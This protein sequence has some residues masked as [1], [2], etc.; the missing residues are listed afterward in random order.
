MRFVNRDSWA[1]GHL[2]LLCVFAPPE[3]ADLLSI[4]NLDLLQML[5]LRRFLIAGLS[6]RNR[7]PRC[8][9]ETRGRGCACA[10][11]LTAAHFASSRRLGTRLV[12]TAKLCPN[13][14]RQFSIRVLICQHFIRVLEPLFP[15]WDMVWGMR[16]GADSGAAANCALKKGLNVAFCMLNGLIFTFCAGWLRERRGRV[17]GSKVPRGLAGAGDELQIP[18][19]EPSFRAR[20][21]GVPTTLDKAQ[22]F[23]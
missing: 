8:R 18:R 13:L 14:S 21:V 4:R 7:R 12:Y 19:L 22:K 15:I 23:H 9:S 16:A 17:L 5:E 20:A 10:R 1:P 11:C 3:T 6:I 2:R